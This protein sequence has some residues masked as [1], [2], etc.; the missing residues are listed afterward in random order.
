METLDNTEELAS[1]K[2][3]LKIYLDSLLNCTETS[4]ITE[5]E[6]SFTPVTPTEALYNAELEE[7]V[8]TDSHIKMPVWATEYFSCLPI[9]VAEITLFLP[10]RQLR[11]V[12][13]FSQKIDFFEDTPEWIMG[14]INNSTKN[15]K[16]IDLQKIVYQNMEA[17]EHVEPASQLVIIGDGK[18]GL[19]CDAVGK[20][21]QLNR[22]EVQWR[23]RKTQRR[24]IAGIS[25][26]H[27]LAI[28]DVKRIEFAMALESRL[29]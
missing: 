21:H 5:S 18:W 20:V 7:I 12:M 25:N 22:E 17:P 27:R 1:Q 28:V 11:T 8:N 16:I 2:D 13:P 6:E 4:S 24:W 14:G 15:V 10:L 26:T 23:A 3:A 29:V 19:A 9:T